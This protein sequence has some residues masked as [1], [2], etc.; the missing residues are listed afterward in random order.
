MNAI[1]FTS[2]MHIKTFTCRNLFVELIERSL[3]LSDSIPDEEFGGSIPYTISKGVV[4]TV[5]SNCIGVE[6][7]PRHAFEC[8]GPASSCS[9]G[10][11]VSSSICLL[12]DCYIMPGVEGSFAEYVFPNNII[13]KHKQL[14]KRYIFNDIRKVMY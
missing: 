9:I 14:K 13:C 7:I 8:Q 3:H 12:R 5:C 4:W 11:C 1:S 10:P 2:C 6:P